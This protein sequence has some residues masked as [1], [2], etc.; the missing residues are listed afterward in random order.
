ML[1]PPEASRDRDLTDTSRLLAALP[2]RISDIP[3]LGATRAADN[4]ALRDG[5]RSWSFAAL[6]HATAGVAGELTSAGDR[7]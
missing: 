7:C 2:R 4:A 6:E 3:A 5:G 1:F